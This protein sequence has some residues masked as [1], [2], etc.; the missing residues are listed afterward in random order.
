MRK[1]GGESIIEALIGFI[2]GCIGTTVVSLPQYYFFKRWGMLGV[3]EW[4]ENQCLMS[5]ILKRDPMSLAKEGLILHFLN[6]GLAALFYALFITWLDIFRGL[7]FITLGILYGILLWILTLA[8][9]HKPITGV[10]ITKHPLGYKPTVLSL[11]MHV[12]YGLIVA[13]IVSIW[14]G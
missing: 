13:Y 7:D 12:I 6:G 9:I 1:E 11:I 2:A 8:P 3:L 14:L 10:A 4:H 5:M